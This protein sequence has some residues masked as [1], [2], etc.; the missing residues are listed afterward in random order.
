MIENT[1]VLLPGV[2][3]RRERLLWEKGISSWETFLQV[4]SVKG[5]SIATKSFH[6]RRLAEAAVALHTGNSSYFSTCLAAKYHWR[7]YE[8]FRDECV[9]LDIETQGDYDNITLVG[10]SDGFDT[11]TMVRCVNLDANLLRTELSRY[12]LLVT[13]NGSS[14]DLP[15]LS[16]YFGK[17]IPPIPHIDLMHVC[18]QAGFVGG[19][20][21]IEKEL[22]IVRPDH[23]VTV[24]GKGASELWRAYMAS[25]EERY[26]QTLVEYNEY[27]CLN[28]KRLIEK[29]YP[30]LK[31]E[32]FKYIQP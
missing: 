7:L 2:A 6:N 21:K 11:K 3:S 29:V 13:F 14:F 28:L 9:F 15:V 26:L 22:G 23:L 1:F 25:G 17:V 8:A 18:A 16:K 31:K 32:I 20:K 24:D 5:M 10:L 19:L 27:D 30:M 4:P 12:K